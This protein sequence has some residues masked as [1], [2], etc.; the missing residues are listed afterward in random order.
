MELILFIGIQATGKSSFY[1]D[2]FFATH[3]RVNLDML[4]TRHR[5]S[6]LVTACL[7]GKTPLVVDNTNLNR[8][9]RAKYITG[10][11][12]RGFAVKGYFFQSRVADSLARNSTRQGKARVPDLAI[13]GAS[14]QMELPSLN[15]GF[16]S[17]YFVRLEGQNQFNV[18]EWKNE[19]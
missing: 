19:I 16:D 17:L 6:L 1:R 15:E 3:V 18:E 13:L 2:R 10:A 7:E 12:A 5:E 14:G 4:K 11:K 8:A 9:Y